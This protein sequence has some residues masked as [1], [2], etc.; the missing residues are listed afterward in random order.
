M[1]GVLRL[2]PGSARRTARATH[3]LLVWIG[4][5]KI[6]VPVRP[7]LLHLYRTPEYLAARDRVRRRAGGSF[8]P[9][10]RYLGGARCEQCGVVDRKTAL[11]ACGW[12]APARLEAT[13][14]MMG[15]W[16]TDPPRT[17]SFTHVPH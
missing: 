6:T 12:W 15:G 17:R 13:G 4:E 7:E 16:F 8:D 10:G 11:R 2:V 14:L 3:G 1:G 9:A 5:N